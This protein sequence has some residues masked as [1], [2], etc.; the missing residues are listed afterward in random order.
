MNKVKLI[1]LVAIVSLFTSCSPSFMVY[2]D[3]DDQAQPGSYSTFN[4]TSKESP[5]NDPIMGSQINQKRITNALISELKKKGY[6]LNTTNPDLNVIFYTDMQQKQEVDNLNNSYGP[7]FWRNNNSY[8]RSYQQG[9]LI[10]NIQDNKTKQLT[11]QGWAVGEIR[12]IKQKAKREEYI[13]RVV[14]EIMEEYQ[15]GPSGISSK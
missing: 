10:V 3:N 14:G 7:W 5:N 1:F 15:Y 12:P 8:M 11:W 13:S 9:R 2:S 4:V 6:T